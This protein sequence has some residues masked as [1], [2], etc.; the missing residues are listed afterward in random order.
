MNHKILKLADATIQLLFFPGFFIYACINKDPSFDFLFIAYFTV[1]GYQV[2]SC[3]A[4]LPYRSQPISFGRSF[5]QKALLAVVIAGIVMLPFFIFYLY[6]LLVV[7]PLMAVFYTGLS[8]S[9]TMKII[10][11]EK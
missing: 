7:S 9:E 11:N 6:A 4:Q 8:I 5:Y 10:R 2:I 3:L 1:G